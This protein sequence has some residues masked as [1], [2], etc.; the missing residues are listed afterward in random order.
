M[1][2]QLIIL[3]HAKSDHGG[4]AQR[5]HD[6]ELN[7]R[8]LSDA[9]RM[10]Q[11]LARCEL[12]PDW[13]LSSTAQRA[14]QTLAGVAAGYAEADPLIGVPALHQDA[15]IYEAELQTLLAVLADTP[16][17][18]ER[19]LLVGH[20]PGLEELLLHLADTPIPTADGNP[21]PTCTAALL[22]MPGDWTR[23][24]AACARLIRY[25]RPRE[26]A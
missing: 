13:W 17:S 6:R 11:W 26:L 7:P 3:R 1:S 2:R 23:L 10:G 20:N 4:R 9:P 16:A 25:Q 22:R 15:R 12:R 8:G 19:V 18:S 5:D 24:S 21:L 14:V